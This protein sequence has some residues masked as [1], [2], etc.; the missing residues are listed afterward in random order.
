[1]SANVFK[2]GAEGALVGVGLAAATGGTSL[3]LAAGL[4]AASGALNG[5]GQDEMEKNKPNTES[6]ADAKT[7]APTTA[8]VNTT[9]LQSQLASEASARA[10][11]SYLGGMTGVG[12]LDQPS[13]TSSILLGS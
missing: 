4:G 13:T 3:W 5:M 8:Q 2:G 6:P 11:G 10:Y 7:P 12:V 1:M 9:A